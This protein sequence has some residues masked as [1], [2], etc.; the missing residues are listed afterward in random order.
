MSEHLNGR[1]SFGACALIGAALVVAGE[2]LN[3]LGLALFAVA[4]IQFVTRN[5]T[6]TR[7]KHR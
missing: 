6:V 5:K 3:W 2:P 7:R 1:A 4:W